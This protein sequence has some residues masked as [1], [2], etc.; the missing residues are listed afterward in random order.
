MNPSHHVTGPTI[1]FVECLSDG[2]GTPRSLFRP[3]LHV[4]PC[5]AP[6]FINL[7]SHLLTR[8]R[9]L[10]WS[11]WCGP[12][13]NAGWLVGLP[14][15]ISLKSDVFS[16]ERKHPYPGRLH[17]VANTNLNEESLDQWRF[18][19]STKMWCIQERHRMPTSDWSP[20]H[21]VGTMFW[22]SLSYGWTW[23]LSIH[24][25]AR[26]AGGQCTL[27]GPLLVVV[28]YFHPIDLY[29]RWLIFR[30]RFGVNGRGHRELRKLK[31]F[32]W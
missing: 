5:A 18:R 25:F 6:C 11:Q 20:E 14:K 32:P 21:P 29:A 24:D 3:R 28:R 26:S 9:G 16:T 10:D 22:S 31:L 2:W 12:A 19:V 27:S 13:E 30:I 8:T 17:N 15:M 4:L 1:T 7:G 23:C